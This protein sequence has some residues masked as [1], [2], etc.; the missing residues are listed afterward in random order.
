VTAPSPGCVL[1]ASVSDDPSFNSLVV[2]GLDG[3]FVEVLA[4]D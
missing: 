1:R 4:D 2:F 3:I